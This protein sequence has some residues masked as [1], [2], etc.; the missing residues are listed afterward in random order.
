MKLIKNI[1]LGLSV[2]TFVALFSAVSFANRE[3]IKVLRDSAVALQ[4]SRPDLAKSLT[5]L[6]DEEEQE[7]KEHREI[8]IKLSRDSAAV[9]KPS[10]PEL[11]DGLKKFADQKANS[12]KAQE[13][14]EEEN[15][16]QEAKEEKATIK[17]FKDSAAVLQPSN[18]KLAEGLTQWVNHEEKEIKLE[19]RKEKE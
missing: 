10:H 18:P 16:E 19:E 9:L 17:L 3:E 2:M 7:M 15:E 13:E 12:M 4:Q 14:K 5:K 8:L 1:A 6:A 11:A